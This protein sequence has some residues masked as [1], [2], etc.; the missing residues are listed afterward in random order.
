MCQCFWNGSTWRLL[1]T[2]NTSPGFPARRSPPRSS[3]G[4]RHL[5][6]RL[7]ASV[8]Q[9]ARD[10]VAE[11]VPLLTLKSHHLQLLDWR[12]VGRRSVDLDSRQQ[13]VG[14]EILE[15]RRLPHDVVAGEVV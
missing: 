1:A 3:R 10:D 7:L 6:E 9:I 11:Q 15:T 13:R 14:H 12:E 5:V 2:L 4:G 8:A